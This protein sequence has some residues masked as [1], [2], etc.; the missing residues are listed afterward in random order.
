MAGRAKQ[1]ID[2][3]ISERSKGNASVAQ[4]LKAKFV[5]KGINPDSFSASSADDQAVIGKLT[6]LAKDL[7][8][9]V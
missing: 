9:N 6:A 2:T 7:G 5:L 4:A 1:I 3:I 8:V